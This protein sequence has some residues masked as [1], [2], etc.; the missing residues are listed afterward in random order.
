MHLNTATGPRFR[1]SALPFIALLGVSVND[2][3]AETLSMVS[4]PPPSQVLRVG[5]KVEISVKLKYVDVKPGTSVYIIL[6]ALD[7]DHVIL[8]KDSKVSAKKPRL[9]FCGS[10]VNK[11]QSAFAIAAY[12]HPISTSFKYD[13]LL[14]MLEGKYPKAQLD[15]FRASV[16]SEK[17][18]LTF[19]FVTT[20]DDR[21]GLASGKIGFTVPNLPYYYDGILLTPYFFTFDEKGALCAK[22]DGRTMHSIKYPVTPNRSRTA[23]KQTTP[24]FKVQGDVELL[25]Y[26]PPG[27]ELIVGKPNSVTVNVRYRDLARDS[28]IYVFLNTVRGDD[29]VLGDR[30][31][32]MKQMSLT[33]CKSKKAVGGVFDIPA[34]NR[35]IAVDVPLIGRMTAAHVAHLPDGGSGRASGTVTFTPPSLT[36]YYNGVRLTA[37]IY[38][39]NNA[40]ERCTRLEIGHGRSVTL[41]LLGR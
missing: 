22:Y 8:E 23:P 36:T 6:S 9:S 15:K 28:D 7:G 5:Q 10:F 35:P 31:L 33:S 13:A 39:W 30:K 14:K 12:N 24:R 41:P 20:L 21:E 34:S 26:S 4:Y 38:Q 2:A 37:V 11:D 1:W 27:K 18:R 19:G 16:K 25:G 32:S 3:G 29:L 17:L 40:G